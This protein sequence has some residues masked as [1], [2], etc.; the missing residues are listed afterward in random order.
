VQDEDGCRAGCAAA[1]SLCRAQVTG[2]AV[3][4]M[5]L[6]RAPCIRRLSQVKLAQAL[7]VGAV[8]CTTGLTT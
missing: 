6:S 7:Q 4:R 2:A 8:E 1:G 3:R 5:H